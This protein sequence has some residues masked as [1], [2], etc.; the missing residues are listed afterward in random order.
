MSKVRLTALRMIVS[1]LYSSTIR[2]S[3]YKVAGV[4]ATR[5]VSKLCKVCN[6][7]IKCRVNKI[8]ELNLRDRI[9][10]VD[11]HAYCSPYDS[12]LCKRCIDYSI[13]T[14]LIIQP[15]GGT[16]DTA[17]SAH[18]LP[19]NNYPLV[20]PHFFLQCLIYCLNY[21]DYWHFLL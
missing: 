20:P 13:R 1:S 8:Q 12:R 14:K 17:V 16:K 5:A 9:Q 2:C 6:N 21:V 15:L 3:N 7:L 11:R 10:S 18:V 19:K 4:L